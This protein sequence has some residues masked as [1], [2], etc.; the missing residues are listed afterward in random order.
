MRPAFTARII[1]ALNAVA[2]A[3]RL[4]RIKAS[5]PAAAANPSRRFASGGSA[6]SRA[7]AMAVISA[8]SSLE[9]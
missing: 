9:R 8:A 2:P 5:S 1:A 7:S 6:R 3:A 4:L